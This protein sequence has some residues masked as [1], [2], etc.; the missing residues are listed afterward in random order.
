M[1]DALLLWPLLYLVHSTLLLGAAWLACRWIRR[2]VWAELLW[3]GAT[4]PGAS[5]RAPPRAWAGCNR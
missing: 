3:R 2:P 4:R 1:T 5:P